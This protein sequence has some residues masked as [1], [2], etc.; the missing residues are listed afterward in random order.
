MSSSQNRKGCSMN[1]NS[2]K[3]IEALRSGEF[4]QVRGALRKRDG[5]CCLGVACEVYRREHPNGPQW[6]GYYFDHRDD[7]LPKRVQRWL[8][9]R[10]STGWRSNGP[11]LVSLNDRHRLSFSEIA[12]YIES[13][14]PGL[15][16]ERKTKNA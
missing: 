6:F 12:D 5:Y 7:E 11:S 3:W 4:E 13:E 8:G 9:L 10:S 16:T 15:F 2:R 14:P 1:D